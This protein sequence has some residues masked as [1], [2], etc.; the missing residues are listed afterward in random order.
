M[1][2]S[3]FSSNLSDYVLKVAGEESYIYGHYE[4]IQFSYIIRC[5]SKKTDITLALVKKLDTEEDRCRDV[6]DVSV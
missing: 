1:H 4:L 6:A 2:L 5:I 3:S